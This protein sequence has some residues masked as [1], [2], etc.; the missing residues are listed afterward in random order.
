MEAYQFTC[1]AR[2]FQSVNDSVFFCQTGNTFSMHRSMIVPYRE[3]GS[4]D[5][6]RRFGDMV[7]GM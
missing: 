1:T 3:T 4:N 5:S 6:V 7:S 2:F